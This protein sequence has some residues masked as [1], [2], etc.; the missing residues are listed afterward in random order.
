MIAV[1]SQTDAEVV[2]YATGGQALVSRVFDLAVDLET[3][4][5][6]MAGYDPASGTSP[7]ATVARKYARAIFDA[8]LASQGGG[9]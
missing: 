5:A 4:A 8:Y 1:I 6:D 2:D 9:S 3:L 7:S